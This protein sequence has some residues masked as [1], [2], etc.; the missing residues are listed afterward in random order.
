[1]IRYLVNASH[2][3]DGGWG[4]HSVDKSTCFGT[5]MNYLVLRLLGLDANHPVCVKARKTLHRLG[6]ALGNPHWGKVWL[7]ILGLYEYEGV[8][9]APPELWMLPYWFPAHPGRWWVHVRAIYAPFGYII[10]NKVRMEMTP[11]LQDL[12][13]E[14][15]LPSQLPYENIHFSEHRNNVCGVDL[16]YPHSKILNFANKLLVV[17]EKFRPDW[18]RTLASK[19]VYGLILKDYANTKHL[20]IAPVSFALDMVVTFAVE[21]KESE[22]FKKLNS[23]K[24]EVLFHGPQG[25]T[26]MGTN[27]TQTW[28]AAFMIQYCFMAGLADIPKH[29]PMIKKAFRYLI[30]NQFT[31]DCVEGSFRDKRNGAW[32]F[33]TKDQGYTVS[34]CTAEAVKAI[35]MVKNHSAFSDIKDEIADDRLFDAIN[36]LLTLQNRGSYEFG[37]FSTYEKIR[38]SKM[39]ESLN[40]AEVFN[41]IMV[42]YPYVECTDSSVLGLTY[43]TK[44]YPEYKQIPIKFAIEDAINYIRKAQNEDGSWYGAWGVCY[45]YAGMFA[46]EAFNS[47]GRTYENDPVVKKGCE[48]LISKQLSD[49]GWSESMKSCET[50]SYV[51]SNQSLVVQTAWSVI[52]LLLA[53]YPDKTPIKKGIELIMKRQLPTGEWKFED[54][55]GVF[56]HSCAIEYPSYKFL[57]SI[58]A[59]GLYSKKYGDEEIL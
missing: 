50:H 9:P 13:N 19:H 5:T 22:N 59:L 43:F 30:R 14:I 33:S 26:V 18:I 24:N 58:K 46:L 21:G 31:D 6:G 38:G 1:M 37:S 40:P 17:Y 49:G 8:N 53:D 11:L 23:R 39:L 48:F 34:D 16:Y 55:E 35:I 41:N 36:V 27:G 57:F 32:G 2:P 51:N 56:N 12:R 4:L 25:M 29:Q 28:D 52:G 7:S 3:V 20:T 45:T 47:V 10:M 15:Y 42:E 44:Y 54:I